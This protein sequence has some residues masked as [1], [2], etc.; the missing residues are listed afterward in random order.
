MN[1]Y[2]YRHIRIDKNIPFYIGIG[3]K[4]DYARAYDYKPDKRNIYWSRIY[5][6]TKIEIEILFDG[7]TKDQ[8]VEKEKEFIALYGRVDNNTGIL[9]NMTD[10]GD[11]TFGRVTT[12]ELREKFRQTKIGKLNPQ[13][14]KKAS[15]ETR[16]KRSK[17]LKGQTRTIET[18]IKQSIASIKSGQAKTTLLYDINDNFLGEF[19]SLSEACRFA[20][21]NPKKYSGKAANV[22]A[23]KRNYCKGYKFKYKIC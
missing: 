12:N 13:Y 20:G 18:K 19:H 22:A 5:N 9:A 7:L 23:N 8:A 10:G 3:N 17:S 14:G 11:G 2:V 1:W 15:K 21:L 16:E 6:K 4:K